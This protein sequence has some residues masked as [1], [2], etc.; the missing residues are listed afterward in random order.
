MFAVL[1]LGAS[2]R[3]LRLVAGACC[4]RIWPHLS[5][6]CS[7]RVIELIELVADGAPLASELEA[8]ALEAMAYAE[9]PEGRSSESGCSA[10]FTAAYA[11]ESYT[12]ERLVWV[13]SRTAEQVR[14]TFYW[15]AQETRD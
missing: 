12:G 10:A 6:S 8:T 13:A 14:G 9:S 3:K 7:R 1:E 11:T 4:R 5:A 2:T 15:T